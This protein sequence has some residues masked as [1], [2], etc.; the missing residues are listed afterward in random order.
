MDIQVDKTNNVHLVILE[1]EINI[2]NSMEL[3]KVLDELIDSGSRQILVDFDKVIFIDSSGL[4][5]LINTV[6][7]LQEDNGHLRL[8]N[9][10]RKIKGIFEITKIHKIMDICESR[11]IGLKEFA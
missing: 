11:E 7:N 10:N 8:C 6:S 2:N 1:G 4:A 9:V 5:V 3:Q